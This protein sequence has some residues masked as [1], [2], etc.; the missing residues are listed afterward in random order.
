MS[1]TG[2]ISVTDL[3]TGHNISNDLL[4]ELKE[5]ELLDIVEK[6]NQ[7]YIRLTELPRVEKILRLHIDLDI[8]LEGVEVIAQLLDRINVMQN[9]IIRLQNRLRIYE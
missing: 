2:F 1:L 8:N 6:Q 3:C 4:I 7:W 9:E 5:Y